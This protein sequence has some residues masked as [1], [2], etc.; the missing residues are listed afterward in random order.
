M[1]FSK[2]NVHIVDKE[3][4]IILEFVLI[5]IGRY[6]TVYV[7]DC[8][9]LLDKSLQVNSKLIGNHFKILIYARLCISE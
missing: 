1:N 5:E 3:I 8:L 2:T 9:C 7:D 4:L 6:T